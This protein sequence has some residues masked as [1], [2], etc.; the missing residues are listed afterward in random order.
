MKIQ[1][2]I[3][4]LRTSA[5]DDDLLFLLDRI[6]VSRDVMISEVKYSCVT[7]HHLKTANWYISS[8][9]IIAMIALYVYG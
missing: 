7:L 4:M 1:Y 8:I 6:G 2:A 3:Y 9:V 5:D